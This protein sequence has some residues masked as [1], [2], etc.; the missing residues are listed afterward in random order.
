M[1]S[2]VSCGCC[3]H[4]MQIA[5][6]KVRA[7]VCRYTR[8]DER[9]ECRNL[10]IGEQ[11]LE[12]LLFEIINKQAQIIMNVDGLGDTAELSVKSEQ[13]SEYEKQINNIHD[14]KQVLYERLI[15]GELDTA[16]YKAEKVELDAE[17]SRLNRTFDAL[18]AETA[19]LSAA[20]AS[21]DELRKLADTALGA[22]TLSR[23]LVELLIDK[24]YVY[25]GNHVEIVW[26]VADFGSILNIKQ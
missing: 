21:G 12:N 26:K 17:L 1:R 24:V 8:V 13:K 19:V 4:A 6:R 25:P 11:E 22:N 15:S 7:F 23:Q 2:K 18:K 5:P 3:R 16:A 9:A 14:K 20:A 10:E